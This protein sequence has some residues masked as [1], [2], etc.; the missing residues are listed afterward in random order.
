MKKCQPAC[1]LEEDIGLELKVESCASF[2]TE[3]CDKVRVVYS[4]ALS[5]QSDSLPQIIQDF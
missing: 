4:G 5:K 3:F 1:L 2:C